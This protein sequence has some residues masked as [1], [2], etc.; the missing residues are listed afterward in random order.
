[1][2]RKTEKK[3]KQRDK[4]NIERKASFFARAKAILRCLKTVVPSSRFEKGKLNKLRNP[5]LADHKS[6]DP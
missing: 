5:Y 1:M 4:K 3:K 6:E 2:K